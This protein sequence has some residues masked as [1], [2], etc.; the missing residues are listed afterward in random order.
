MEP[1]LAIPDAQFGIIAGGYS[2]Q[3]GLNPFLPGDDDGR[4][5]V[6]TTR[7][8]GASD[9][10]VVPA[11]HEFIANDPRVFNYT[12]SFLNDGYFVAA[13]RRQPISR[14]PIADQR[15]TRRR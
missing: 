15:R 6:E 13:D 1:N 5:T 12:L 14:D 2:N 4:I 8:A 3:L 9:F 7:L 10:L 11:V